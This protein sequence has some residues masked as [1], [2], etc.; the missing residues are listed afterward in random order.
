M[1]EGTVPALAIDVGRAATFVFED[2]DWPLKV[3]LLMVLGLLPGLNLILWSGYALTVARRVMFNA[4]PL[5][6]W[7]D[8]SDIAVR[9]LLSIG[10]VAIYYA[11]ALV[12]GCVL[13]VLAPFTVGAL[14]VTLRC[15]GLVGVVGYILLVNFLLLPGHLRFAQTDQFH[16]YLDFRAR[17]DDLRAN[18]SLFS[19]LFVYQTLLTLVAVLVSAL[20]AITF[21]GLFA[22]L[23]LAFLANGF[24][25]GTAGAALFGRSRE[26]KRA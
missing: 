8:W 4:R 5:P 18:T 11:P 16:S 6:D 26:G 10:G 15:V 9:G 21:I 12:I 22:V 7:S 14:A 23:T 24:I 25:L 17:F 2:D 19:T 1:R 20:L 13:L 3:G